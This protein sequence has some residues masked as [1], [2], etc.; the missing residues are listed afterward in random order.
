MVT[1][2]RPSINAAYRTRRERL[3]VSCNRFIKNCRHRAGRIRSIGQRDSH[4]SGAIIERMKAAV[5]APLAGFYV[6]IVDGNHLQGTHHRLKKLRRVGD[7]ALPD[8]RFRAQSPAPVDR[9]SDCLPRCHANQKP[10]FGRY[11]AKLR[12]ANVVLPTVILAPLPSY[13]S[14]PTEAFFIVR[15]HQAL[16]SNRSAHLVAWE[17]RKREKFTNKR[18]ACSA[19]IVAR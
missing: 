5:A 15:H 4:R 19:A 12:G 17:K 2:I 9:E 8:T 11:S 7:A 6:R 13:S 18:C 3:G 10:L 14:L 16:A 1:Q